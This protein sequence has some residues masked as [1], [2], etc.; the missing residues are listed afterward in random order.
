MLRRASWLVIFAT[1][2]IAG[3]LVV[4]VSAG[5]TTALQLVAIYVA[6][7]AVFLLVAELVVRSK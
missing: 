2:F 5:T 7:L 1:V 3:S 4:A 6:V